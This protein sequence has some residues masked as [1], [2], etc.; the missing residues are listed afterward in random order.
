VSAVN[1]LNVT[2][3]CS[4]CTMLVIFTDELFQGFE[5][6]CNILYRAPVWAGRV[7]ISCTVDSARMV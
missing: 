5:K 1:V 4:T 2:P 3:Q 7:G 6:I